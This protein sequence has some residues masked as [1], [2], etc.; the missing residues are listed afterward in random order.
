MS[1][2][3]WAE[4][5][6]LV[7]ASTDSLLKEGHWFFDPR[8]KFKEAEGVSLDLIYTV[9]LGLDDRGSVVGGAAR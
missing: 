7:H 4:P 3:Q 1:T 6:A 5:T 8:F 9:G 2:V